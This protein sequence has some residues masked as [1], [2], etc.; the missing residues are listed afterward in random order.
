MASGISRLLRRLRYG[1]AVVVVSGLPRSGTSMTMKMLEA[2]GIEVTTDGQREA[3][4]DNP[5]G[6][7]EDERVK[8]LGKAQD[9]TWLRKSR[10]RAIKIISFL[11]KDLPSD[12]SYK[13]IFMRRSIEEVLASQAKMLGN[14]GEEDG[15]EDQSMAD[16]YAE[17]LRTTRFMLGYRRQFDVLY[18][19]HREA[20]TTPAAV[21]R[22]INEFL[23]GSLDET[24]MAGVVDPSLYRNRAESS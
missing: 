21:A 18:V 16:M 17:N 1:R 23:G 20:L 22:S 2:G 10:G 6:Y 15:I 3:D 9:R 19:D 4:S 7:Y 11:L 14:L 12:N 5:K 13:V 8:N 24:A